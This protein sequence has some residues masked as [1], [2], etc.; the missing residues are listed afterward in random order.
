MIRKRRGKQMKTYGLNTSTIV[1]SLLLLFMAEMMLFS[2]VQ[3][4][5]LQDKEIEG[6]WQ[7]VLKYSGI[8]LRIIFTISRSQDNTITATMDVP[9][10]N[11]TDIP[12]DKVVFDGSTLRLE[13]TPIEG[14]F[15]GK[16]TEDGERI[17]GLE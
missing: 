13:I 12:V 17:D 4:H 14:V 5:T 3:A 2:P 11:A 8:E 7:G 6:M 16:L 9:E 1:L 10:Q 15:K